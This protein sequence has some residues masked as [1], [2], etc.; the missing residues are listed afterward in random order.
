MKICQIATVGRN[1]EWIQLGLFRYPTSLLVLITTQDYLE[2]A[3]EI[4][5]L[6]KGIEVRIE[7]IEKPRDSYYIVD[8]LK[9]L[10]NELHS[11]DYE[12]MLNVTSGLVSW[13]LLFYSTATILKEKIK[14]FYIIDKERKEPME[15]VLYQKL[16]KTEERVLLLIPED[17][18]KLEAITEK[19]KKQQENKKGSSGLL[20]RYL[21]QLTAEGLVTS[22]GST[23]NKLF[24]LTEKGKL[25][26]NALS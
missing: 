20:S 23:K 26:K 6:V 2:Q 22:R 24:L 1:P 7:I 16:S 25:V 13:Q 9:N 11:K 17:G 18:I 3:N 14:S 10:V 15:M 5:E 12:L 19:Y 4:T 21:K 8:F